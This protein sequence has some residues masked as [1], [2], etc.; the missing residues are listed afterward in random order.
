MSSK[1]K[2]LLAIIGAAVFGGGNIIYS[3]I[4]LREIP[5][6]SFMFLRFLLASLLIL[7]FYLK[8][9]LP[10]RRL[11]LPALVSLFSSANIFLFAFGIRLTTAT[12]SQII[13]SFVPIITTILA[14]YLIKEKLTPRKIFGVGLGFFG[15]INILGTP[16]RLAGNLLLLIGATFLSFYPVLSKK[17]QVKY[18]P[19][20]LTTIFIFTTTVVGGLFSL[21]E[22]SLLSTWSATVS[23]LAW[24]SLIFVAIFGT[25]VYYWLTQ[26]AIKHGS[27]VI[28]SMI[29]YLQPVTTYF[30]AYF[31]LSEQLSWT[32]LVGGLLTIA[33]AYLTTTAKKT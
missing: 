22:L 2:A 8:S 11:W 4:G 17:I 18:S 5:P 19:W 10:F 12:V 3:K 13:Y 7:P 29:L 20:K 9:P 1:T 6:F 23:I 14:H 25:I 33:G 31:I 24:F 16:Q 27:A 30:W 28:G 26:E 21:T 32:I 15:L